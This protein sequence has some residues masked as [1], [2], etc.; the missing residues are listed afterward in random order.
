MQ[1]ILELYHMSKVKHKKTGVVGLVTS[2]YR[3][4]DAIPCMTVRAG[5]RLFVSTPMHEWDIL[6][7]E[8]K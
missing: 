2:V 6:I 4:L 8:D 1:D 3:R 5:E 7:R